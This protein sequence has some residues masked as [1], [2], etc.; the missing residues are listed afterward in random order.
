MHRNKLPAEA[1]RALIRKELAKSAAI[2]ISEIAGRLSVS[3]MTIR[4][5][6]ETLQDNSDVRRTHGGAVMA[7]R[8]AFEFS[9]Q[10]RHRANLARKQAIAA[11][12]RRLI[13]HGERV[14]LD[15]GTT[16]FQLAMLLK[17]CDGCTVITPSLAVA[18][19]L[20]FCENLSV[21]LLGGVIHKGSPDLTGPVTMHSLDL[22]AA[23]WLFQGTEGVG[24]DGTVYNTDL[25]LAAVD[26]KMRE[27]ATSCCLL[28]DGS[29][30]GQTALVQT[31]TLAGFDIVIT[32]K[33]I[34]APALRQARKLAG[35][36]LIA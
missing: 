34:P 32:E 2:S 8:M 29:K 26:R 23:D 16:T 36:V 28:A 15:T 5:D 35:R 31:G 24:P 14:I 10:A 6:L 19:E 4:R 20:Q 21:I 7:E 3:E 27:K 12:A 33:S 18:S 30:F 9:Y 13:Q 11:A 25:Q 1:R 17:D 22:F